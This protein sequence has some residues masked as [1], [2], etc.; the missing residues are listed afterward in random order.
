MTHNGRVERSGRMGRSG[1]IKISDNWVEREEMAT[2]LESESA[3]SKV[4]DN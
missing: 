1:T 4:C 3:A 2:V